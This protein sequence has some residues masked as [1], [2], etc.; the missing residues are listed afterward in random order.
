MN[1]IGKTDTEIAAGDEGIVS[2]YR[3]PAGNRVD[4]GENVEALAL[5]DVENGEFVY[6]VYVW[7]PHYTGWIAQP[8]VVQR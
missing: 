2:V 1:C 5:S 8:G 4:S 7:L 3:G 6:L